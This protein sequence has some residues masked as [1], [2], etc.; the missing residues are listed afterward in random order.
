M[1]VA[2]GPVVAGVSFQWQ[3]ERVKTRIRAGVRAA[4]D[5]LGQ[6]AVTAARAFVHSPE[7]SRGYATGALQAA[8]AYRVPRSPGGGLYQLQFGVDPAIGS[9]DI[10]T[11]PGNPPWEYAFWQEVLPAPTGAAYIRPA[12]DI[13]FKDAGAYIKERIAFQRGPLAGSLEAGFAVSD[14]EEGFGQ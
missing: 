12:A 3:G 4:L 14:F 6:D 8:I 11:R 5:D 10:G 7:D 13:V 2:K 9:K 1:P